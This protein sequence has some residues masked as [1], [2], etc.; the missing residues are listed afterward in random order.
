ME[1][2]YCHRGD[3]KGESGSLEKVEQIQIEISS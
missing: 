2:F 1:G 3:F